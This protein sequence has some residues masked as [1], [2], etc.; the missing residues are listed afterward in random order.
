MSSPFY[1][2]ESRSRRDMSDGDTLSESD[3]EHMCLADDDDTLEVIHTWFGKLS[4]A[5]RLAESIIQ[6]VGPNTTVDELDMELMRRTA[7]F[8]YS[9]RLAKVQCDGML[10]GNDHQPSSG[11]SSFSRFLALVGILARRDDQRSREDIGALMAD[12]DGEAVDKKARMVQNQLT[13]NGT[14][15]AG[16]SPPRTSITS[17]PA[18]ETGVARYTT[19]LKEYGDRTG[20]KPHYDSS[21]ITL[22][23]P[24]FRA[25]VLIRGKS[26]D[27]AAVSKRQAKHLASQ[28]ACEALGIR[29]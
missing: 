7:D 22:D 23:P 16:R 6:E 27:E 28:R 17:F 9:A 25:K 29:A 19:A 18:P 24:L 12:R 2:E 15:A 4:F 14:R 20:H 11:Q 10:H 5:H 26:F 8:S 3:F 1:F 21:C 13:N